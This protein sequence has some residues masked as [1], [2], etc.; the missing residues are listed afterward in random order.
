MSKA[1]EKIALTTLG[2]NV[3]R[4]RNR[5]GYTQEKLAEVSGLDRMTLAFIEGGRRWPRI[6]TL[7][8]ISKSLQV[9]I[10]ELFKGV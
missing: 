5:K 1:S 6:S 2:K 9:P 10:E 7:Q 3:A 8:A 4:L